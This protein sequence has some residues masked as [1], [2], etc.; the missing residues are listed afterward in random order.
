VFRKNISINVISTFYHSQAKLR[1]K[2]YA[3]TSI[4][5]ASLWDLLIALSRCQRSND[6]KTP[7]LFVPRALIKKVRNCHH[8]SISCVD[9]S[10]RKIVF[11]HSTS[12]C[13]LKIVE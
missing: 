11:I 9:F 5:V 1:F 12:T 2:L 4:Y 10:V 7:E 3:S 8:L 6:F 13:I